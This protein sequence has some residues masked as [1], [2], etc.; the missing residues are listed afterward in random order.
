[1]PRSALPLRAAALAAVASVIGCWNPNTPADVAPAPASVPELRGDVSDAWGADE[2]NPCVPDVGTALSSLEPEGDRLGF[3]LNGAPDLSRW[4]R[5]WQGIQR[6]A[7]AGGRYLFLSR[8]GA[9]VV[10]VVV[11]LGSRPASDG[12]L[13]PDPPMPDGPPPAED[14]VV[15]EV[16]GEAG[17]THAG[18]IQLIGSVLALPLDGHGGS[19]VVFYDVA[20]PSDPRRLAVM[21]H[22]DVGPPSDPHQ[23]SA[24][25]IT[26]LA[27]GR[28]L[29]VIGVHSSKALD[30]Y[31]STTTSLRDPAL[32]FERFA[33]ETRGIV[34]GFQSLNLATQCDGAIYLVGTHNNGFP[35]PSMGRDYVRWYRLERGAEGGVRFLPGGSKHV[36]CRWCNFGAAGGIYL[37]PGGGVLV[38]GAGH[39][40]RGP[41]GSISVEEFAPAAGAGPPAG[42]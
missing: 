35:P 40:S 20:R 8:S 28:F 3:H 31:V 34:R 33:T 15:A 16:P 23:A 37:D 25:G 29:L 7:G 22:G 27:D 11:R 6:A 19:E 17:R 14:A 12:R 5:H 30:F 36:K 18:G 32:R 10:L 39:T 21:D 42:P 26:R 4:G 24:A 9:G 13:G 2:S 38:Y 1:M 41:G